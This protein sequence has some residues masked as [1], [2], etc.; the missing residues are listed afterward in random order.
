MSRAAN[1]TISS[2]AAFKSSL[3][4]NGSVAAQRLS[5]ISSANALYF[6]FLILPL[7]SPNP[8]TEGSIAASKLRCDSDANAITERFFGAV[9]SCVPV[10]V[11]RDVI[12]CL[13]SSAGQSSYCFMSV[14][15][16]I[17]PEYALRFLSLGEN[18]SE[19]FTTSP[20]AVHLLGYSSLARD[21]R[22]VEFRMLTWSPRPEQGVGIGRSSSKRTESLPSGSTSMDIARTSQC[23]SSRDLLHVELL[24]L[25]C[26][27][28]LRGPRGRRPLKKGAAARVSDRARPH[29]L[30]HNELP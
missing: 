9:T 23:C 17:R 25:L 24:L 7:R 18:P 3:E 14:S 28:D 11:W 6:F 13:S 2:F 15:L 27:S 19:P 10:P 1:L 30:R 21:R 4:R 22:F 8:G 26:C 29:H 16:T 20:N 5:K 12:V